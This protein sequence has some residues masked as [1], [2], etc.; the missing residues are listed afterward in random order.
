MNYT[1]K[2]RL[3]IALL[4][5]TLNEHRETILDLEHYLCSDKFYKDSTLQTSDILRRLPTI[6]SEIL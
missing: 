2:L 6:Y 3:E 5:A 4:K 1:T